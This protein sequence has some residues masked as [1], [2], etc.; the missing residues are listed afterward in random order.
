[1]AGNR[2]HGHLLEIELQ[3]A[4]QNRHRN[5]LRVRRGQNEFHVLRRFFQGLQHGVEGGSG[6]H[7]H[8]VDHIHL[9]S[10][11]RGCVGGVF[12]QLTH[13]VDARIGRSINFQQI[14]EAPGVD[15]L[16]GCALTTR[17]SRD[18]RFAIQRFSEDAGNGCLADPAR[19]GK[20]IGVV[21][22]LLGE[23][24]I[25]CTYD[26]FLT[27]QGRE[28]ARSPLARE[29]LITHAP[30]IKQKM[31]VASLTPGT[32]SKWLWLLPSGPDQ[33][34]HPAMRGD[35]PARM[36]AQ[37]HDVPDVY[38]HSLAETCIQTHNAPH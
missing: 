10:A 28:I 11:P 22:T 23:R 19:P 14:N 21:Q 17:R 4:R 12:Q 31:K 18:A 9:E 2:R 34:H 37:G 3:T 30:H 6:Q 25:E 24:M 5:F 20:E 13:F 16:A 38:P 26:V 15:F 27:H 7:V 8:F 35:P 29:N 1:M 36:I 33:V 32:C